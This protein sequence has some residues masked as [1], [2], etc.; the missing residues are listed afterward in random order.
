MPLGVWGFR[1]LDCEFGLLSILETCGIWL[2][3]DRKTDLFS[4]RVLSQRVQVIVQYTL[5][6]PDYLLSTYY[7]DTWTLRGLRLSSWSQRWLLALKNS[8]SVV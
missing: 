6:G 2:S 7:I 4:K 5:L 3:E 8:M 1:D